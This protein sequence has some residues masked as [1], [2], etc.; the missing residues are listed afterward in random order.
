MA[1]SAVHFS[2][3]MLV[4]SAIALPSLLKAWRA[5]AKLAG[6]FRVWMLLS[7]T[8]GVWAVVPGVLRCAGLSDP[9]CDGWWMNIFLFYPAINA[10]SSGGVIWGTAA[11]LAAFALQYGLLL[12]A[13]ARANGSRF[14]NWPG[15]DGTPRLWSG[16]LP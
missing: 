10:A 8:L 3:G 12:A 2:L 9:V 11:I 13:L 6:R 7:A 1:H 16:P 4:G 5:G 14:G 15:A